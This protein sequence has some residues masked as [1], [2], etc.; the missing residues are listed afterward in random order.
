MNRAQF[1]T[2]V[3]SAYLLS[4][5]AMILIAPTSLFT[6]VGLHDPGNGMWLRLSGMLLGT[7]GYFFLEAAR[8]DN[9]QFMLWGARARMIP[10]L[11]LSLFVIQGLESPL[12]L[13]CG[14]LDVFTGLWTLHALRADAADPIAVVK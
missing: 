14:I 5:G 7:M 8:A 2:Y 10:I 12:V 13:S 3:W 9:R 1:S 4:A 11:F 6:W